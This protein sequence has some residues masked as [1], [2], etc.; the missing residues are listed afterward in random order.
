VVLDM[1]MPVMSGAECFRRLHAAQPELPIVLVSGYAAE[2][3]VRALLAGGAAGFLD[4]PFRAGELERAI[5]FALGT[6]AA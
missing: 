3:E 6:A 5:S 2:A 4:K 1:A